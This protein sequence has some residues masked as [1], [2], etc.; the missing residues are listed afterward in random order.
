M[1][2]LGLNQARV[3]LALEAATKPLYL[4]QLR[5]VFPQLDSSDVAGRTLDSLIVRGLVNEPSLKT[6]E[7][8]L[9][10][11]DRF[12]ALEQAREIVAGA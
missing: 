4:F 8:R 12:E 3:L 11:P 7:L 9:D 6:W 10:A 5:E 2:R 1:K